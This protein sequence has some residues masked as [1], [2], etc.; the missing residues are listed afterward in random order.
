MWINLIFL[1]SSVPISLTQGENLILN[2]YQCFG[3]LSQNLTESLSLTNTKFSSYIL[4]NTNQT[5]NCSL[6][7]LSNNTDQKYPC[8]LCLN[9]YYYDR[10]KYN[11]LFLIKNGLRFVNDGQNPRYLLQ[12]IN[13][14]WL[15][16]TNINN[17]FEW[18]SFRRNL[19]ENF[20]TK[21][22]ENI[23]HRVSFW[24]SGEIFSIL[25]IMEHLQQEKYYLITIK[26][27]VIFI[28]LLLF[29]GVLGIFVTLTTLLNFLTCIAVLTLFNYKLTIENISYFVIVLIICSQY[30]VL[31]SIRYATFFFYLIN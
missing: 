9:A 26:F 25:T 19:K 8:I 11:D 4:S 15:L 3:D 23:F 5:N 24:Y 27:I 12:T 30:S 1:L 16:K 21:F 10:N 22:Y 14:Q 2:N 20:L 29:T 28:F 18:E 13:F 7:C 31:Y 17:Y 6:L